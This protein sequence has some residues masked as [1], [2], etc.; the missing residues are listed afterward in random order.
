MHLK[1]HVVKNMEGGLDAKIS[2]SG[3]NLS[4]GQR[5]LLSLS[6]ALLVR[7]KILVLDEAT[8]SIDVETDRNIQKTIREE[9]K[10]RTIITIAHRLNTIADSDKIVVL[11]DGRV[12]EFGSPEELLKNKDSSFYSLAKQGGLVEN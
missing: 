6:R 2:E 1:D 4:L 10:D 12:E 7:S 9:F 11:S 5:Q 3:S 8:A